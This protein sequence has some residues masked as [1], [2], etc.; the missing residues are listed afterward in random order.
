MTPEEWTSTIGLAL[1]ILSVS[2]LGA[3]WIVNRAAGRRRDRQAAMRRH[4]S[5]RSAS[6]QE[7]LDLLEP[8]PWRPDF[9]SERARK[10]H[11]SDQHG[12]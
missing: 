10:Y 9:T 2:I 5:A 12:R 6:V 1:V 3:S 8:D 4:P 11:E 7:I